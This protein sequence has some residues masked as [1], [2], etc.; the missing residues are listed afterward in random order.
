MADTIVKIKVQ[1]EETVQFPGICVNCAEPGASPLP[2]QKRQ[3]RVTRV[4]AVPLCAACAREAARKSGEEERFEKL[5]W[6]TAAGIGFMVLALA[7]LLTPAGMAFWLRLVVGLLLGVVGG[8]AVLA[9]FRRL[10][11]SKALPAKKEILQAAALVS[12]SWRAVTFKFANETFLER[13]REMNE[14]LLMET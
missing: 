4:V 13:F 8:T 14:P 6:L 3:G 10:S 12:F 5:G 2:L 7:L 1:P 9:L 11:A